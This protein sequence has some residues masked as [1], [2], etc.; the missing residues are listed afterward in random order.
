MANLPA[1]LLLM[2]PGLVLV[3]Q[4]LQPLPPLLRLAP[5]PAIPPHCTKH[6]RQE[7]KEAESQHLSFSGDLVA[8]ELPSAGGT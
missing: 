4:R 5:P 3:E 2:P 7:E 1:S 6:Q 8:W